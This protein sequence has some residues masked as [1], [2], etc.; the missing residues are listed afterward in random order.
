M[1]PDSVKDEGDVLDYIMGTKKGAG[2]CEM[3]E[4]GSEQDLLTEIRDVVREKD[5]VDEEV[6]SVVMSDDDGVGCEVLGTSCE[7]EMAEGVGT[8][9]DQNGENEGKPWKKDVVKLWSEVGNIQKVIDFDHCENVNSFSR[10]GELIKALKENQQFLVN[11]IKKTNLR[12]KK[13]GNRVDFAGENKPF[14]KWDFTRELSRCLE[15]NNKEWKDKFDRLNR[16]WLN[17]F[18]MLE[19]ELDRV[20][21]RGVCNYA[22]SNAV[23]IVKKTHSSRK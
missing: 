11:E 20:C 10:V 7:G 19:D 1:G 21:R 13:A 18:A 8:F 17:R 14:L 5:L 9:V 16:W 2:N 22:S 12:V 4:H 15:N 6:R 3:M 23:S